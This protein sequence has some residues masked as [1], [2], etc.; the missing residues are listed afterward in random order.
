[1]KLAVGIPVSRKFDWRACMAQWG[2]LVDTVRGGMDLIP[3]F[4]GSH[5][6]PMPITQ[7]R[8][9]ITDKAL[10]HGAD[11]L[12]WLDSDATLEVG[13]LARLLSRDL[14]IVSALCFKRK[15]PVT[16][17]CGRESDDPDAA[18]WS[19]PAPIDDVLKWVLANEGLGQVNDA[20]LLSDRDGALLP[21]DVVGTH[22]TLVKREVFERL[23]R[24]WYKRVT[25]PDHGSTGSDWYFCRQATQAGFPVYVDMSVVSGHLEGAHSIGVHD[26]VAWTIATRF[27]DHINKERANGTDDKRR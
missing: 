11:Y 1:M 26:F 13:S 27:S 4:E 25:P 12:F 21:V 9:L 14:P 10:R 16:P 23:P 18:E 15:Y 24:P 8:N 7:T 3:C 2:A 6:R 19:H 5:E 20:I 17:A 22:A